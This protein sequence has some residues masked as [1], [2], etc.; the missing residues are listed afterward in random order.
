MN[1]HIDPDRCTG[2]GVCE[3]LAEDIFEVGDDGLAH[4]LQDP[5]PN[6][7]RE[8]IEQAVQQCPT[9]ALRLADAPPS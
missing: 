2:H 5:P 3:G 4:L 9:L 8:V 7:R 6:D 1:I